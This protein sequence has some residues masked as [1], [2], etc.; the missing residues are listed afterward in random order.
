[1]AN[2]FFKAVQ[3]Q[4]EGRVFTKKFEILWNREA[5]DFFLGSFEEKDGVPLFEL[6]ENI[7]ETVTMSSSYFRIGLADGC[8]A[9]DLPVEFKEWLR[10][11]R[12][13][14]SPSAFTIDDIA[15]I[16]GAPSDLYLAAEAG[17]WNDVEE[18]LAAGAN[19]RNGRYYE[20]GGAIC[21]SPLYHALCAGRFD[22]AEKLYRAGDR[23]DDLRTEEY[24]LKPRTLMAF[25]VE[26]AQSG[27]NYFVNEAETFSECCR[28]GLFKQAERLLPDAEPAEKN[29]ALEYL[30][31]GPW[32]EYCELL[33]QIVPLFE[34]LLA[35]G[36][37]VGSRKE[38][39]L[40]ETAKLERY[41]RVRSKKHRCDARGE[42]LANRLKT[43]I[44]QSA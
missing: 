33:E 37:E 1:M 29:L 18:L 21:I 27:C 7:D 24:G 3:R 12:M 10:R 16:L 2:C 23:L 36:A 5:V 35:D 14:I 28:D 19:P 40:R 44:G 17:R 25:L 32:A 30:L 6:T 13:T 15:Q 42:E 20:Y 43:L 38:A 8:C 22:I 31:S 34:R 39:F 9:D 11:G 26:A 41:Y 4:P